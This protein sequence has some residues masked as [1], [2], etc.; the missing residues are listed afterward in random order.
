MTHFFCDIKILCVQNNKA[1]FLFNIKLNG[2]LTYIIV[3]EKQKK[4]MVVSDD[5]IINFMISHDS[6]LTSRVVKFGWMRIV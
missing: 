2:H 6:P 4:N 5:A 3:D 1:H